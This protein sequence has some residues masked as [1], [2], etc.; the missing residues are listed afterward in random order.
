LSDVGATMVLNSNQGAPLK[1]A[2]LVPTI[3]PLPAKNDDVF[4]YLKQF[5]P[6]YTFLFLLLFSS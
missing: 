4:R 6:F 2:P 5:F 3:L 1:H